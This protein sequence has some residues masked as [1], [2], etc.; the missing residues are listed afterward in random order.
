MASNTPR[1]GLTDPR[2]HATQIN[3]VAIT[4]TDITTIKEDLII[5]IGELPLTVQTGVVTSY[6]GL[7]GAVQ[8][9]SQFN[10]ATGAVS[11]NAVADVVDGGAF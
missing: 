1:P 3:A 2:G 11:Y 6:N 10:G 5:E 8:G 9:V 4:T 7:T